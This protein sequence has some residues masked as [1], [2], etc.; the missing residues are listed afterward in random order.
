MLSRI[1]RALV[2]LVGFALVCATAAYWV[3]KIVTPPPSSAPAPIAGPAPRDPDPVLAARMF[4]LVQ[5]AQAAVVTNV[6]VAGIFAAGRDSSAVLIVDNKPARA[7]LMGQEVSPGSRLVEVRPNGVTLE[8]AGA[9]QDL[10]LAGQPSVAAFGGAAPPPAFAVQGNTL[11]APSLDN[12]AVRAPMPPPPAPQPAL[13][14]PQQP[15]PP[16]PPRA[17]A[18]Q[19][20]AG[21]AAQPGVPPPSTQ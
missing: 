16:Q 5:V 20:G 3:I 13:A 12:A 4:G 14:T 15:V 10:Q 19:P 6:Q 11:S 18:P 8:S 1:S 9:R 21:I 2:H 17:A 7:F